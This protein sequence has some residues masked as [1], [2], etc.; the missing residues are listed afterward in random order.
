MNEVC[1]T[2]GRVSGAG[3]R[4]RSA[5]I[6]V[7]RLGLV[8]LAVVCLGIQRKLGEAWRGAAVPP[9]VHQ[10]SLS[11]EKL[12][13]GVGHVAV[14]RADLRL[15]QRADTRRGQTLLRTHDHMSVRFTG[16]VVVLVGWFLAFFL[17][18]LFLLLIVIFFIII[19]L[20]LLLLLLLVFLSLYRLFRCICFFLVWT[21]VCLRLVLGAL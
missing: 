3:R 6:G 8:V 5:A 4:H 14:G 17:C 19:F 2:F 12:V 7:E 15:H 10:H 16:V 21:L 9:S 18:F 13:R 20:L 1:L 11:V